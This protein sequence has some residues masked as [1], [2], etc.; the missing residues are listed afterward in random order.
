[1]VEI[2]WTK[3]KIH[4]IYSKHLVAYEELHR[5]VYS[6]LFNLPTENCVCV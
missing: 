1:M 3:K 2:T 6:L 4:E 5:N